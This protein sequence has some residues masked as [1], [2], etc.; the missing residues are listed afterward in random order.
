MASFYYVGNHAKTCISLVLVIH[1]HAEKI[2]KFTL[3]ENILDSH[4]K[5]L[6]ILCQA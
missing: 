4:L 6:E 3:H 5:L 2:Y 1:W